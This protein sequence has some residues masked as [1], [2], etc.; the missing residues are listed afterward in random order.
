MIESTLDDR[1]IQGGKGTTTDAGT[2]VPLVACWPG[3]VPKR[4]VCDDLVDFSDFLATLLEA[5]HAKVPAGL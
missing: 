1:I 2:R 4:K 3:V 5:A